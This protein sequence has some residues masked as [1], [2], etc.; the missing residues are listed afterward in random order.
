[1]QN[2]F[3]PCK[4]SNHTFSIIINALILLT[5]L[6]FKNNLNAQTDTTAI[7]SIQADKWYDASGAKSE[8]FNGSE[9]NAFT[10]ADTSLLLFQQYNPARRQLFQYAYLGN[11][12]SP[13][14][15]RF[16]VYGREL[17]FDYGRHELD[18]YLFNL[19]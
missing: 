18:L 5:A 11:L 17:G 3:F 8:Y 16:F 14:Y 7:D 12:G 4:Y 6:F 13:G 9:L 10:S 1:M 2:P 15:S 19:N